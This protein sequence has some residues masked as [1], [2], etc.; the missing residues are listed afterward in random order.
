MTKPNPSQIK[1]CVVCGQFFTTGRVRKKTC[2]PSCR[3]AN[4]AIWGKRNRKDRLM[5][6]QKRNQHL[7]KPCPVCGKLIQ[8][9]STYCHEHACMNNRAE[10]NYRWKGGRTK[11]TTGYI[12]IQNR[13]H[14]RATKTGYV[15]EHIL[16][17]EQA[18]G[19]SLAKG[20]VIHHLNGIKTDNRPINLVALSTR[21]H[22]LVFQAKAK[23]I[24]ELEALLNGQSQLL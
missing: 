22:A 14:P 7:K 3:R 13:E 2:S 15:F 24:Q 8:L 18:H 17:W 10:N 9:T 19:K 20:W 21:K 6:E 11:A 12:L 5:Y 23:R 16:V 1:T 4:S